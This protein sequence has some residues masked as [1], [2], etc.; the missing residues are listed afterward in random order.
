[1]MSFAL[2]YADFAE[3]QQLWLSPMDNITQHG[4]DF[5]R[6][7]ADPQSWARTANRVAVFKLPVN[8]LLGTPPAIVARGLAV[9][10]ADHIKLAVEL[11]AVTI[12]KHVCGDGMEGMIWP[13]EAAVV[14]RK[15]VALGADVDFFA[16]DLPLTAGHISSG[17]TACHLTIADTAARLAVSVRELRAAFPHV[18][19]V[20]EEVPTGIPLPDWLADLSQWLPAYRNATGE[21][22]A[23]LAMDVWWKFPWRDVVRETARVLAAKHIQAGIFLDSTGGK[24]MLPQDWIA[25][26]RRNACA[27]RGTG[28]SLDFIMVANWMDPL[29]KNLPETDSNT[30]TGLFDWLADGAQCS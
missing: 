10:R 1:M 2:G 21:D 18:R 12:D 29:V 28:A 3:A 26:T 30:L 16:F 27:L 23:G 4:I 13:H 24:T 6:F 11:S 7:F 19:F 15:L 8:Y 25:D 9:L 20:D 22:L 17:R 5:P 14:A